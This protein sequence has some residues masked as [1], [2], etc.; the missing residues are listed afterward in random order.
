MT[1]STIANGRAA[2]SRCQMSGVR[3]Q[4]LTPGTDTWNLTPGT[5][6][7][8][9]ESFDDKT[10]QF[11]LDLHG[12]GNR[13]RAVVVPDRTDRKGK[14]LEA[15]P[16]Q[17]QRAQERSRLYGSVDTGSQHSRSGCGSRF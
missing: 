17:R 2:A 16:D 5:W 7:L 15:Q 11:A 9:D 3:R 6:R 1:D 13:L 4:L 10:S 12:A 8:K 14:L